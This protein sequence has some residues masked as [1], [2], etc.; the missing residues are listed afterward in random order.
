MHCS[1]GIRWRYGVECFL[2]NRQESDTVCIEYE[3]GGD[4]WIGNHES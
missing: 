4:Y 2:P 3:V 1:F